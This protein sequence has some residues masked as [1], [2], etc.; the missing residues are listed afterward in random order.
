M[1]SNEYDD[2]NTITSI[3]I[4]RSDK[5]ADLLNNSPFGASRATVEW[6]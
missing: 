4:N 2:Y 1:P 3:T 6:V 5:P